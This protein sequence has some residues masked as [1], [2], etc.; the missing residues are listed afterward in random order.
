[1]PAPMTTD[2]EIAVLLAEIR[3][4]IAATL[5]NDLVGL[6]LFGSLVS[7]DFTPGVSD[8]DLLAVSQRF[9]T[10]PD[11][12]RLRDM[13]REFVERHPEW[14]DRIEVAYQSKHGLRTWQTERSPMGIISPGEPIH[15]IEAGAEWRINWFFVLDH[16][17]TLA[18]PPPETL[19]APITREVFIEA[20]RELGRSWIDRIHTVTDQC[21]ESYAILTVCRALYSHQAGELVSKQQAARWVQAR[22]PEWSELIEMAL[23]RRVSP[24]DNGPDDSFD[25]TVRFIE[26]MAAELDGDN[27]PDASASTRARRRGFATQDDSRVSIAKWRLEPAMPGDFDILFDIHRRAMGLYVE[28]IWGWDDGDQRRRFRGALKPGVQAVVVDGA[29]VGMLDVR[30]GDDEVFIGNIELAPEMQGRGIGSAI[31]R[32][33]LAEAQGH[34]VPVRLHVFKINSR[35]RRLYDSLGFSVVGETE[36]HYEMLWRTAE[37]TRANRVDPDRGQGTDRRYAPG[38]SSLRS[39]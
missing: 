11:I 26:T 27:A 39:E 12:D 7:G 9:M 36:L 15:L 19:I 14:E 5:G 6:Y 30:R 13:H 1:M 20:A 18:G 10:D 25:D 32:S 31:I 33:V 3:G 4:G 28:A 37:G 35:A 2:P 34:G 38:D 16:G 29:I 21:G 17:V 24:N 8:I 22:R 23:E